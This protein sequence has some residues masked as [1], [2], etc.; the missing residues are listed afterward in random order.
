MLQLYVGLSERIRKFAADASGA[1]WLRS[2]PLPAYLETFRLFEVIEQNPG[3][4]A[5]HPGFPWKRGKRSH[6]PVST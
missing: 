4:G 6:R 2:A 5:P 1:N 3:G